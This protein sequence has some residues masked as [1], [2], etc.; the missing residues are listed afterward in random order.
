VSIL[1]IINGDALNQERLKVIQRD[2][3]S[4]VKT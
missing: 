1:E 2:S 3:Y 4:S